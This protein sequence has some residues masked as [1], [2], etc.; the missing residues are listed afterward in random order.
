VQLTLTRR[1]AERVRLRD[2]DGFYV[3]MRHTSSTPIAWETDV[4]SV[5]SRARTTLRVDERTVE[6]L[7]LPYGNCTRN[8]TI[9]VRVFAIWPPL[10]PPARA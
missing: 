2:D 7:P 8:F 9:S 5:A 10:G 4:H 1:G 6:R 3:I